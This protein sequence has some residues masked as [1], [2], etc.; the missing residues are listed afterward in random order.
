M[1]LYI[2]NHNYHYELENLCRV[3]FPNE[4]INVFKDEPLISSDEN[5]ILTK[6][7]SVAGGYSIKIFVSIDNKIQNKEKFVSKNQE[8]IDDE[9]ERIFA[10]TLFE[11][12]S[13]ITSI[14]PPWGI[15]TGVR[16]IKLMRNLIDKNGQDEAVLYFKNKLLVSE[17]KTNLACKVAETQKEIISLSSD[18]SFSL[19]IS[20]P[21]CPTRCSYCS[22]VSQSVEKSAKLIPEYLK[23]L[24]LELEHTSKI[25]K[26]LGLKIET[27]YIGGGTPT[28]L[29]AQELNEL[30]VKIN[31]CFDM[32]SCREFT[33][34]AGRPD[35]ITEEKLFVLKRLGVTRISI[36][37]QTLNNNTL[38]LIG[39]RHTAMQ[40][41]D[42]FKLA[43]KCGFNNINMDLIAGL[44][45]E[46]FE[47]F[48]N[49]LK[50]VIELDP[51]NITVHTLA[52]KRS[53]FLK[54]NGKK[55]LPQDTYETEKMVNFSR[56]ILN[57]FNYNPYYLYRQSKMLGNLEN[58]GF[59]KPGYEN[60][61]NIYIM[62]EIHSI[63]SCG[64]G[65]VTKLK[66]PYS[67]E[68]ERIFNFKFAYEYKE[69]FPEIIN[70]KNKVLIFYD[71]LEKPIL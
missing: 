15:L 38:S 11:I 8:N 16:P 2:Q 14:T 56:D 30:I 70:R 17:E 43:R 59:C 18:K 67:N 37:P 63:I 24:Q 57:N 68:I 34:E 58:V 29:S 69:R 46:I 21:F 50:K 66:N 53:S 44:P 22:F 7:E 42:S 40:A 39:R 35:T 26:Q 55:I 49:T 5:F 47:D 19:Y 65:G 28:V 31:L 45:N 25:V 3:F 4:K 51:E 9:T 62:E 27:V 12:L 48:K 23:L 33:V 10:F 32:K 41:I 36:N 54:S 20:I 64:A 13:K 61:Y 52:L 6:K 60:L 1:N 71:N